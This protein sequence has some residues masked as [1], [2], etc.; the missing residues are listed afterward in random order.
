M[1]PAPQWRGRSLHPC[2]DPPSAVMHTPAGALGTGQAGQW[3]WRE[4]PG[5]AGV[6]CSELGPLLA[7]GA[8]HPLRPK[9]LL[10]PASVAK[11]TGCH[12]CSVDPL[13]QVGDGSRV[14]SVW[15][16]LPDP[17]PCKPSQTQLLSF[18]GA[19]GSSWSSSATSPSSLLH[20]LL[21]IPLLE[22]RTNPS[23][24]GVAGLP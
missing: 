2:P 20:H 8:E 16:V 21:C 15:R 17:I 6:L 9:V 24:A 23:W 4:G 10:L 22:C 7:R 13:G 12:T 1:C 3:Q 5:L 18:Q 19:G 11:K 14:L